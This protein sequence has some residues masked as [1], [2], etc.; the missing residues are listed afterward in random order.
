MLHKTYCTVKQAQTI[1]QNQALCIT[2]T[3]ESEL[4]AAEQVLQD[5][6]SLK[7]I[8]LPS[9]LLSKIQTPSNV[10]FIS[11]TLENAEHTKNILACTTPK[12]QFIELIIP[13]TLITEQVLKSLEGVKR[14]VVDFS[15][16]K[17]EEITKEQLNTLFAQLIYHKYYPLTRGL[18]SAQI[19]LQHMTE[20]YETKITTE[21]ILNTQ[22]HTASIEEFLYNR[23]EGDLL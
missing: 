11:I 4:K 22:Q 19:P 18:T 1:P 13:Y 2:V 6:T 20:F 7:G 14:I 17:A 15:Q 8:Q 16:H 21:Q 12:Q 23:K 5:K 10:N 9:F 3:T